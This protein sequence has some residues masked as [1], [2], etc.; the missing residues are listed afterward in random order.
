MR[1][2]VLDLLNRLEALLQ[3]GTSAAH[4]DK[5]AHAHR[6]QTLGM[7][8]MIRAALP[9]ELREAALQNTSLEDEAIEALAPSLSTELAELV[10]INQMRLLRR[11]S[12]LEALETNPTLN[13]DQRRRLR[14]ARG[15]ESGSFGQAAEASLMPAATSPVLHSWLTVRRLLR[16]A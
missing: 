8:H 4:N 13:N 11:T 3:R 9:G 6:E 5:N 14:D 12:L 1:D 16:C 7:V 10:V 2:S 15:V